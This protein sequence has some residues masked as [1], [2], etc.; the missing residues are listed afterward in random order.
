M[1]VH[2]CDELKSQHNA[3]LIVAANAF[4]TTGIV[5]MAYD[6]KYSTWRGVGE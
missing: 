1:I 6:S 2:A 5:P 3:E 4:G